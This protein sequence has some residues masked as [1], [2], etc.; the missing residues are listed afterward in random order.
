MNMRL[1]PQ[2]SHEF[3]VASRVGFMCICLQLFLHL[4]FFSVSDNCDEA[5]PEND[6]WYGRTLMEV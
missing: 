1:A 4:S 3:P 2:N 5:S 6:E